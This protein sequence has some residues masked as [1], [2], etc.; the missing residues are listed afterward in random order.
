MKTAV[1]ICPGRGTYT[2]TELGVL[3]RH[4]ADKALLARFDARR[5]ALGQETLSALDGA[6]G[7]STR[8]SIIS[9]VIISSPS[10]AGR[11]RRR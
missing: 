8:G 2:K 4:F 11:E 1:V 6:A 3:G 5:A 7:G 9:V 10:L